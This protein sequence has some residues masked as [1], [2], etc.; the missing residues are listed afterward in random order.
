MANTEYRSYNIKFHV[1]DDADLISFLETRSKTAIFKESLRLY[2]QNQYG[3]FPQ[4][5]PQKQQSY[6]PP[7]PTNPD[8]NL[9][10][11]QLVGIMSATNSP[12]QPTISQQA[13]QPEI[14][15]VSNAQ[16]DEIVSEDKQTIEQ[17]REQLRTLEKEKEMQQEVQQS[18]VPASP[19]QP[20]HVDIS[21]NNEKVEATTQNSSQNLMFQEQHTQQPS[22]PPIFTNSSFTKSA[23]ISNNNTANTSTSNA[24]VAS[25]MDTIRRKVK[26]K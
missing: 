17:L 9:I 26:P 8:L 11:Q 1:D 4:P 18:Q 10:L 7:S 15:K 19:A 3:G 2:I 24:D 16:Q 21:K 23:P 6:T 22:T 14:P 12:A 25:V 13:V 20:P 5:Q